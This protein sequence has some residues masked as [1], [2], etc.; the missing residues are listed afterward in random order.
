M[1]SY[2]LLF[3]SF[4]L[5]FKTAVVF[6]YKDCSKHRKKIVSTDIFLLVSFWLIQSETLGLGFC[7][8]LWASSEVKITILV[9]GWHTDTFRLLYLYNRLN[10][11]WQFRLYVHTLLLYSTVSTDHAS[12][13]ALLCSLLSGWCIAAA[14]QPVSLFQG[15]SHRASVS[16][17]RDPFRFRHMIST[18][19]LQVR[20]LASTFI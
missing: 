7:V 19:C 13:M 3:I 17:D 11:Y 9:L 12:V 16:D 4:Y 14:L 18:D 6:V 2:V 15:A 20:A 1:A 5:V 8:G 10:R